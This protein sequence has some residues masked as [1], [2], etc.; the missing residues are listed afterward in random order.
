MLEEA[1]MPVLRRAIGPRLR[2]SVH[3][4]RSG[5]STFTAA[6]TL[7]GA[8]HRGHVHLS[9]LD[10]ADFYGS[11]DRA[12]L[13]DRLAAILQPEQVALIDAL[14][15]APVRVSGRLHWAERGVPLGRPIGPLVANLYLLDLD[16]AMATPELVEGTVYVRYADDLLV[17]ARSPELRDRAEARI[18]DVLAGLRLQVRAEKTERL[19][20]D[21]TPVVYLGHAV[22]AEGVYER[23]AGARLERIVAG[24]REASGGSEGGHAVQGPM[25]EEIAPSNTRCQTLYVTEPGLYLKIA[26][27]LVVVKRGNATVREIAMHRIDRVMVLAAVSFSSGFMGACIEAHVPVLFYVGKGAGFGSL[28]AGAMPNPLRLRAQYDLLREPGRKMALGRAVIQA[29]VNAMMRR[30]AG[31]VEALP[32]RARLAE[33]LLAIPDAED[34]DSLRGIEGSA[35]RAYYE[36][37][38]RRIK[39]SEF[40]FTA[41]SRRPPKDPINSLMSFA[42]SMLFSEMQVALL[43]HGL[44][45]HP[46]VLH[47][48]HRNHPALASDLIEPYRA[49]IADSYVLTLVNNG[50]VEATGFTRQGDGGVYM[51]NETRRAF[52]QGF[53]LFLRRPAGGAKGTG[54]PRRLIQAA[55]RGML[56][57]VLGETRELVL[58]LTDA[59]IGDEGDAL[60]EVVV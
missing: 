11:I 52:V 41:R 45:P 39:R 24:A 48:L 25:D 14:V 50:Q 4:Y 17:A 60:E 15:A 36:G 23:V 12:L 21:G 40:A 7:V 53:E 5:R 8:L 51:T 22:D 1:L 20:Y 26:Q 19:T 33:A 37:F 31:T 56:R 13:H 32:A 38:A 9:M 6:A 34:A 29:K 49:L 58:P 28:V 30:L 57:V 18:A 47:E 35:T 3:G 27:G 16:E 59:S 54:N 55:A 2:P 46:G 44:D 42:Y 10:V 43:T